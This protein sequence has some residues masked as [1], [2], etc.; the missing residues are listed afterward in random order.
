[1][2]NIII[3][4]HGLANKPEKGMLEDGWESSIKEGLDKNEGIN[5]SEINFSSVYWADILYEYPDSDAEL[6][7]DSYSRCEIDINN[8]FS[9]ILK[10][11]WENFRHYSSKSTTATLGKLIDSTYEKFSKDSYIFNIYHLFLIKKYRELYF[12]YENHT[13]RNMVRKTLENK[14]LEN[15]DKKIMLISHSMGTIIA[16]DVLKYMSKKHPK[17]KIE[18]FITLGSPL[19]LPY[20]KYRAKVLSEDYSLSKT[21]DSVNKW[22]NFSDKNDI[23]AFDT[24]LS[25]DYHK[26]NNGI[27]VENHL[28]ENNWCDSYHKSYGYLR[29]PKVSEAI[30][31]FI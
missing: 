14:L 19:G 21:P 31:N 2:S 27:L 13:I 23:V 12:Y 11:T 6:Y 22:S 9:N 4:I 1:M 8:D 20:V 16:Y 5:D 17:L 7:V 26:N 29:A 10:K 24:D 30:K 15:S 28:V 18:H 3:G 25:D